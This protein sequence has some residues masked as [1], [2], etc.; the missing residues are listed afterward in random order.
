MSTAPATDGAATRILAPTD[1]AIARAADVLRG[2]GFVAFPTETVY[3]LGAD[4]TN[5]AAVAA[6]YRAKGRPAANPLIVHVADAGGAASFALLDPSARTLAAAFWPGP[7][8][9][10]LRRTANCPVSPAASAGLPTVAVRVPDHPVALALLRAAGLPLA[11]PSANPSGRLSP[12]TARH[13]VDGLG[14]VVDLILDGGPCRV[15]IESTVL[16]LDGAEPVVLRPGAVAREALE[17]TLGVPVTATAVPSEKAS[18]PGLL[19]PHYAPRTPLRLEAGSAGAGEGLLAFGSAKPA[20]AAIT[21]NLSPSGNLHEAAANLY[22]ALREMDA[23]GLAR[24]AVVPIPDE[25]IGRAIND[26]LRR[27]AR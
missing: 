14:D 9:L 12:T 25:G 15:G 5:G 4:A 27:A 13:A 7:L 17:A 16:A 8:T 2:G 10:V 22:A 19:G 24:I 26:R 18:S 3:G 20:A 6:V 1:R 11:A 23:A 21:R